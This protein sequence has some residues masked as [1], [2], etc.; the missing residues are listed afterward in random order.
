M[1]LRFFVHG[2]ATPKGSTRA[3][4]AKRLHRVFITNDNAKTKPWQQAIR[5]EAYQALGGKE[6][7]TEPVSV[8]IEFVFSRPKAHY[9]ANGDVKPKA[10]SPHTK[11]PDLDKLERAVLD[12]MTGLVFVDDSQVCRLF[13]RKRYAEKGESPGADVTVTFDAKPL[14]EVS[15][16]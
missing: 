15:A 10:P 11:K 2:V 1:S 9:R 6:P 3:F 14:D 4:Y 5:A 7:T 12:G 8:E 13:A 16:A